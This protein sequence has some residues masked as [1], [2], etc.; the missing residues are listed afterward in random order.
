MCLICTSFQKNELTIMEAWSNYAEM[1]ETMEPK[2]ADEVF[3]ML[4]SANTKVGFDNKMP[5]PTIDKIKGK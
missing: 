2:H 4:L 3:L 5:K 1:A